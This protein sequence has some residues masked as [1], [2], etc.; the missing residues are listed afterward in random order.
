MDDSRENVKRIL[1]GD[2]P[3]G[4]LHIGHYLGSLKNRVRLQDEYETY[5]LVADVQALTDNFNTPEKVRE[6]IL[7]TTID[8]LAAGLDP[9]KVTFLIQSMIPEIAE[10]TVYYSNLV[11]V[12]RLQRNPTIKTEIAQKK[13]LFGNDGESVTY[14]FLGYPVSQAADITGFNADLVPVGEDQLPLIEQTKEIVRKFNSLYGEGKEIIKE[15]E[16]LLSESKENQRIKGLDGKKMGKSLNN[17]IYLSDTG[18]DITKKVMSAVT[19][20]GKIKKN[21]PANPNICMVAYYHKLF[22]KDN[23]DN[24]FREC[25]EGSRGCV[26][27]KKELAKNIIKELEPIREKRRY[28]ETHK[29]EVR[30]ILREGTKKSRKVIQGVVKDIKE[31]MK[32]NYF[33]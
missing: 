8:N 1:T 21:D 15:P 17:A 3:T 9:S 32:I 20:P 7:E 23:L 27:C 12:S 25:K 18:E 30:E 26:N 31:A 13:E 6:N 28:Y 2:R 5:I 24:I 16:A 19:D 22:S 33:D 14:G 11:T 10:L 4:K 29:D